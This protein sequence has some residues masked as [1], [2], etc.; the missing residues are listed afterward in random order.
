[1]A[2]SIASGASLKIATGNDVEVNFTNNISG[3]GDILLNAGETQNYFN[4]IID[5][6]NTRFSGDN[7]AFTGS[8][9]I[10]D[11]NRLTVTSPNGLGATSGITVQNGGG[12]L[13]NAPGLTSSAPL[14]IA[15]Q[16]WAETGGKLGAVRVINGGTLTGAITMTG[17]SRITA[18]GGTGTL[19]GAIGGAFDLEYGL[20]T[21][22]AASGTLNITHAASTYT[23]STA[24]TRTTVNATNIADS[25][26][27]SSLGAGSVV[28]LENAALTFTGPGAMSSNRTISNGT[29][30]LG[31]SSIGVSDPGATLTLDGA[32]TT[33]L[34]AGSGVAFPQRLDFQQ[35]L[36]A[37]TGGTI[38]LDLA[39]P[40]VTGGTNVHRQNLTLMGNTSLTIAAG[41]I[42]TSGGFTLGNSSGTNIGNA[43]LNLQDNAILT[44]YGDLDI[45]NQGTANTYTVNQSGNSV[46][47]ALRSLATPSADGE[48]AMRIG[49]YPTET[50]VYN[51]NGGTV[52]V[53]N[54]YLWVG[55]D[56]GATMNQNGGTVNAEGLRMVRTASLPATYNFGNG[57]AGSAT[58]NVGVLGF[59]KGSTGTA[60]PSFNFNGGT[61]R[62]TA[63]HA[64]GSGIVINFLT[65][66]GTID[67][68]G[69]DVSSASALL[70]GGTGN[71][72]KSGAGEFTL[73]GSNTLPGATNVDG[74][75][76]GGTASITASTVNVGPAGT[77]TGALTVTSPGGT[78]VASRGTISPGL[79]NG[80]AAGIFTT[81][82][83]SLAANSQLNLRP[84]AGAAGDLV[85]VTTANGLSGVTNINVLPVGVL[86]AGTYPL[87]DY[88]GTN[89]LAFTSSLPHLLGASVTDNVAGTVIELTHAGQETLT[90]TG[91][92]GT[93][94]DATTPNT[95]NGST[96][97]AT[98]YLQ[99][100]IAVFDDSSAIGAITIAAGGVT[101]ASVNFNNATTA[102]TLT[103]GAITGGTSVVKSGTATTI[104]AGDNTYTG[105]TTIS[106]GTLQ[107]GNGGS[108][109]LPGK[110]DTAIA[111]GATLSFNRS[112]ASAYTG[113][114]SGAGSLRS[115]GPGQTTLTRTNSYSGGTIISQGT[116]EGNHD[117]F[118]SGTITLND[119]ATGSANTGLLIRNGSG[120]VIPNNI[121]VSNNGSGTA[122]IGSSEDVGY[123]T[124]L[125]FS[126]TVQLDRPTK[127]LGDL[128]RTTFKGALS[129]A[130]GTLT[131]G[132]SSALEDLEIGRVVLEKAHAFTGPVSVV[133]EDN[134]ILQVNNISNTGTPNTALDQIPDTSSVTLGNNS[135]F[136]TGASG[137]A[138]DG[139]TIGDLSSAAST[140]RLLSVGGTSAD[141]TF[142]TAN[143]TAFNGTVNG[144][145]TF[146]LIKQGTGTFTLGGTIDNPSARL[147]ANNGTVILGKDS[148]NTIHALG[149][150]LVINSGAT[151]QL[152][153]TYTAFRD[154]DSNRDSATQYW[155]TAS[156]NFVDQIY[157]NV[158]VT[159]N[160][161]GTFD[162][163]GKSEVF[164]GLIGTGGT[165][166]NSVA[167][168]DSNLIIGSNASA[169]PI[170][171]LLQNGA[172]TL[173]LTKGG[174]GSMSLNGAAPNTYSGS[175]DIRGGTLAIQN[176]SALGSAA[177]G[178]T[179]WSN[180]ENTGGSATQLNINITA[181]STPAAPNVIAEPVTMVSELVNDL[182]AAV[183]NAA[184]STRLTG[185]LVLQ[186]DGINQILASQGAGDQLQINGGMTGSATGTLFLRGTGEMAI[187]STINVPGVIMAKTDGGLLILNSTGNNVLETNL[188]AGSVRTDVVDALDPGAILRM[189][190]A[191][192]TTTLD[193]N[194][195]NQTVAGLVSNIGITDNFARTINST[196]PATLNVNVP[197]ATGADR[198]YGYTISGAVT[199]QK[200]GAGDQ[201][202]LPSVS[203]NSLTYTGGTIVSE[204]ALR[205]AANDRIPDAT[206]NVVVGDGS[207][208]AF[209]DLNGYND[210]INGLHGN[211]NGTVHSNG[212]QL[213]TPVTAVTSVL[214]VR[215]TATPATTA[216][217][218][219]T[220]KDNV[221]TGLS[222]LALT[223][224]GADTQI[225]S[226]VNTYS[227]P[228]S[229]SGG[230]LLINGNNGGATGGI[231]VAS[232]ATLGGSGTL[233]GPLT[234][235]DGGV[236]SP[237]NSPGTLTT[238][239]SATFSNTS[240]L[241]YDFLGT[242]L[243]VGGVNN[244][245][246]TGVTNLTLDGTLNVAETSPGSFLSA[247][248]GDMWRLINYSGTLLDN[249]LDLGSMPALAAGNSF[250]IDTSIAGQVNLVVVPE[251]STFCLL[252]LSA[253]WTLRRRRNAA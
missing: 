2:I 140:S 124:G 92:G 200:S 39:S 72:T 153:G 231:T 88:T 66:G 61:Y 250:E 32:I 37:G 222:K 170:V 202:L 232:T 53:P 105:G 42:G 185:G 204:G 244:D 93:S 30:G 225:L 177:T 197:A 226:G 5:R 63:N 119:A 220:L 76:L 212:S 87:V 59:S 77:L 9:S 193:L 55:Y 97:L 82:T 184:E 54:N 1:P 248:P 68:N 176:T 242:D 71:F 7:N 241:I 210:T 228:T 65:G 229:V 207:G 223:K 155:P 150:A 233:G 84:G 26:T 252:G 123:P 81:G 127:L 117:S 16:G 218:A 217:F 198:G 253:L 139:E 115:D 11:H 15:G 62:A 95:W 160:I 147:T 224:I 216:T 109:G 113:V 114:L 25:G 91:A 230:T 192:N 180:R 110:G 142:G 10:L 50:A 189:G 157:N 240:V 136:Q 19:T 145:N 164:N 104:L 98:N 131:I 128:D 182:R 238:T 51:L 70:A 85:N 158:D 143:N 78:I 135:V 187:N 52:N 213:L 154:G 237:G 38:I 186:G 188:V 166:T 4:Y 29:L 133:I 239:T 12:L 174:S 13:V 199:L 40:V 112:G 6:G 209:L 45:G 190:Q 111:S 195:K 47:N 27:A 83:L 236:F 28:A 86:A 179:I 191:G 205:L 167:G 116:L 34:T 108:T 130:V 243:T 168:T 178:T 18:S 211:T 57:T 100:D 69:F 161:G 134:A 129:G 172:G 165:V 149:G 141:L 89:S 43:T 201:V 67:T 101:P 125:E 162:M 181:A 122:T 246:F 235:N 194:G 151:V 196:A 46:V 126:G 173:S 169:A 148:S 23:G 3:G 22:G 103:G 121:I 21:T 208:S 73:T 64:I 58:L 245:L 35:T 247:N 33:G 99:G 251:T 24:I 75:S 20:N 90:W 214:T 234:V 8:I 120:V 41:G 49:H 219:G 163:A 107:I 96:S 156:A 79:Q 146:N 17:D 31:G 215:G 44:S 60:I 203:G 132:R 36:T 138:A 102:Y 80:A 221:D 175:T 206:G 183:N 48:R 106:A 159:L 152:G 171:A 137:S 144:G 14:T 118:G 74:G 227:G 56:G 94:W 249:T